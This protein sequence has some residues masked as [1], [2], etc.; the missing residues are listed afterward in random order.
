[1]SIVGWPAAF[2]SRLWHKL[3]SLISLG[4]RMSFLTAAQNHRLLPS[5]LHQVVRG[6]LKFVLIHPHHFRRW[7][8]LNAKR[9]DYLFSAAQALF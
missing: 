8:D 3:D 2:C 1:M 7:L 9:S 4:Y 5:D 6:Q